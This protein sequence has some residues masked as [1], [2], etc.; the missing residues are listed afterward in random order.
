MSLRQ[1]GQHFKYQSWTIQLGGK[2]DLLSEAVSGFDGKLGW[3]QH[4]RFQKNKT[5][6]AQSFYYLE[7]YFNHAGT[8]LRFNSEQMWISR[9]GGI[10]NVTDCTRDNAKTHSLCYP[11]EI[12]FTGS[13]WRRYDVTPHKAGW[14]TFFR[15]SNDLKKTIDHFLRF[16]KQSFTYL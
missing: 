15:F 13:S 5:N 11:T 8:M 3:L 14:T 4:S 7:G 6:P 1:V 12:D 10:K 9:Y 16:F 2:R